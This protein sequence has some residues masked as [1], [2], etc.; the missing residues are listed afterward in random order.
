MVIHQS[1]LPCRGGKTQSTEEQT[2][3]KAT[4]SVESTPKGCPALRHVRGANWIFQTWASLALKSLKW[5]SVKD[6]ISL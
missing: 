2:E 5:A 6:Y 3:S 1:K 4:N